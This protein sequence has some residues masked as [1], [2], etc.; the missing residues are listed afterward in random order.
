MHYLDDY[1]FV[2]RGHSGDCQSLRDT[3][4]KV[5]HYLGVPI[6]PEKREGPVRNSVFLGLKIDSIEQTF[7]IP[8][9]KL[10]EI[11]VKIST[12]LQM[13][14]VTLKQLQSR[15]GSLNCACRAIAPGIAFLR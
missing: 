2:E 13:K 15:I 3:F 7:T 9:E 11:R 14:K 8:Q 12:V 10:V 6:A 5:C 1:F 4:H